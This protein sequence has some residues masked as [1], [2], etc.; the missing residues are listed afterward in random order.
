MHYSR[1]IVMLFR[2]VAFLFTFPTGL[3]RPAARCG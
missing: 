1:G 3:V 2:A